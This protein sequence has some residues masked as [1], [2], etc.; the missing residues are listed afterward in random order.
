ME[1]REQ[2]FFVKFVLSYAGIMVEGIEYRVDLKQ[3]PLCHL[4]V[5]HCAH[6][7]AGYDG[8]IWYCYGSV[9]QYVL[10]HGYRLNK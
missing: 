4:F 5:Y 7:A 6:S 2:T 9:H 8:T 10:D 1:E 3:L